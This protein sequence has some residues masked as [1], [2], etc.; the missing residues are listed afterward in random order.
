MKRAAFIDWERYNRRSELLAQN[1]GATMHFIHWGKRG[2]IVQAPLRYLVQGWQTLRVLQ[3]ERAEVVFVQNPP[4]FSAMVAFLYCWWNGAQYVI[5]SHT[6]AFLSRRWRWS[7]GLHQMLSKRAM[8]TI[9]HNESQ[10]KIVERWGCPYCVLG[11][12]LYDAPSRQHVPRNGH[13]K[14][15]FISSFATDEPIDIVFEAAAG[16]PAVDFYVTGDS[17]RMASSLLTNKPSNCHLT[18]YLPYD[19]YVHLLQ[20]VDFLM[21]LTTRDHTV[22]SGACE[23]VSL[24]KP[25]I[26]SDWPILREYFPL[27]TVH[28]SNSVEGIKE[29]VCR[30]QREQSGL[31]QDILR[32]RERL[33]AQWTQKL[34]GLSSLLQE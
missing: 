17:K 14:V 15:A 26:I 33:Q 28:V 22:L 6:G 9:V 34:S 2:N 24:G 13:F 3:R 8:M 31:Q 19:Q 5:D 20:E 10:E 4:I 32:L 23:A 18:G 16:L 21:A 29:G 12:W 1:L 27:G 25:M 30:A 11:V 7:L